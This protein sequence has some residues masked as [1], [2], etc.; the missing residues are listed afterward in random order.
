MTG[1]DRLGI[2]PVYRSHLHLLHYC[3][4]VPL[5]ARL[6]LHAPE[7]ERPA[8][9]MRLLPA[10]SPEEDCALTGPTSSPYYER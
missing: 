1:L 9:P 10:L 2:A 4:T 8:R 3:V 5:P 7:W 6:G